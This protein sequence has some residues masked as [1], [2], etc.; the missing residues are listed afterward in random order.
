MKYAKP[1]FKFNE[2]GT[3]VSVTLTT[4]QATYLLDRDVIPDELLDDPDFTQPLE[5]IFKVDNYW[6]YDEVVSGENRWF[7]SLT[8]YVPVSKEINI[9]VGIDWSAALTEPDEHE[10]PKGEHEFPN[11]CLD[12]DEV[13]EYPV[14]Q[15]Y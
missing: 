1:E 14:V 9:F 7:K 4:D 8:S 13:S 3:P 6:N 12:G 15:K 10:F 2:D 5:A 11:S